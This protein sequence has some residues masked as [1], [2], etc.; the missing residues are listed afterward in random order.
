MDDLIPYI[1]EELATFRRDCSVLHDKYPR[2][3]GALGISEDACADPGVERLV[4]SCAVLSAR[5]SRQLDAGHPKLIVALLQSIYPHYLYPFPSCSIVWIDHDTA[6]MRKPRTI[7]RGT[8]LKSRVVQGMRCQFRTASDIVLSP[9]AVTSACYIAAATAPPGQRLDNACDAALSISFASTVQVRHLDMKRLSLFIDGD[10]S[11]CAALRDMLFLRTGPAFVQATGGR[12]WHKLQDFPIRP[13]GFDDDEALLPWPAR[14][15]PAYRLLTEY[16]S[17]P[18]KF[19]FIDIDLAAILAAVPE[20]QDGF[21]LHLAVRGMGRDTAQARTLATLDAGHLR[22]HC[23][24]VV[25]L[26]TRGAAPVDLHRRVAEY[27]LVIDLA[28][29]AACELYSVDAARLVSGNGANQCIAELRPFYG[30]HHGQGRPGGYWLVRRDEI[31]A[32]CTPGHEVRISIVD[33]EMRPRVPEA[34]TLSVDVTCSNRDTPVL[35]SHG[36]ADGDLHAN[37]IL[38]SSPIRFLRKPTPSRRFPADG[39]AHWRLVTH[40]TL[41]QHTLSDLGMVELRKMLNLYD[42]P[43]SPVTQRQIAGIVALSSKTVHEWVKGV[44]RAALMAGLDIRVTVD[45]SAYVGSGLHVFAQLL[46]RFFA[47]YG[48]INVFTRLVLVSAA[49]GEEILKCRPR[50]G[51]LTLD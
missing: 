13:A 42:L 14:S 20:M 17:F 22:T 47:L 46:D 9:L 36:A 1:Q 10:P 8:E 3:A 6:Q 11:L 49:T 39:R 26:F 21:T 29:P 40:L 15:H 44:H 31:A 35:L 28:R 38:E 34:Q 4:Q 41:N 2:L 27:P 48:Q 7:S 19:N 18:E 51:T 43:H 16:F 30:A 23:A 32:Q 33:D 25:N 45:E 12:L 50:S 5:I 24:P 37:G